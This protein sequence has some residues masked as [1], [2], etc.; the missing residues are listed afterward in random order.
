M[1]ESF[2]GHYEA[3]YKPVH[4]SQQDFQNQ[5]KY[6]PSSSR[7]FL[8]TERAQRKKE[9]FT[10]EAE[11]T[12]GDSSLVSTEA[13]FG[14]AKLY[15]DFSFDEN[16]ELDAVIVEKR[17]PP[18]FTERVFGDDWKNY[19]RYPKYDKSRHFL[20]RQEGIL[21]DLGLAMALTLRRNPITGRFEI[22][23]K[24]TTPRLS[25]W[26]YEFQKHAYKHRRQ[27]SPASPHQAQPKNDLP[28]QPQI[29]KE[30]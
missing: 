19:G 18:S 9:G 30:M 12:R 28:S 8:K 1:T 24:V 23:E 10:V 20:Y 2:G 11:Y 7:D 25:Q 17:L 6:V 15:R 29:E 22:S 26:E 16:G 5:Q 14:R 3:G 13:L 21:E 4:S 27:M